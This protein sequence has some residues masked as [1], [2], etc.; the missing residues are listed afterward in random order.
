MVTAIR[1]PALEAHEGSAWER[2]GRRRAL[3]LPILNCAV[4]VALDDALERIAWARIAL[5]PVAPI[6]FRA[7]ATEAFLS[8]RPAE[9]ETFAKAA[10]V[11]AKEAQPR[12]S[13]L[14]ASREYRIEVLQVLVRRGLA[15]A[16]SQAREPGP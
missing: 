8:D 14:R 13:L 4:S 1:F 6:P 10:E 12:S 11:T 2:I 15:R 7:S 5:G 3:V 9:E 16:V